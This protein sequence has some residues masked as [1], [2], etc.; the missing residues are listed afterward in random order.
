MKTKH[1]LG[2]VCVSLLA[3][4][5][6]A[7]A[8]NGRQGTPA[9]MNGCDALANATPGLQGLCVA[10]CEA[11]ACDAEVIEI[12]ANGNEVVEY[13]PGCEPSAPRLLAN[14]RNLAKRNANNPPRP[15][16]VTIACPCWTREQLTAIGGDGG[17]SCTDMPGSLLLQAGVQDRLVWENASTFE[18]N[19]IRECAATSADFPASQFYTRRADG[20][21]A[22]A[23]EVCQQT[24]SDECARRSGN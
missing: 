19:G 22:E 2:I 10:L 6:P 9:T 8:Q 18:F 13:G 12:D 11:Q 15:F 17:D 1:F 23:M 21:I 7:A 16:C 20:L 24:L 3:F 4:A 14:Y 5:L